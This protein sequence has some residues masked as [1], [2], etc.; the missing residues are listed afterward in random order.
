[1]EKRFDFKGTGGG[2]IVKFIV[3]ILLSIITLGIY[4]SWFAVDLWKYVCSTTSFG[5]TKKGQIQFE[6]AGTGGQLFVI[7]LVG[8]LLMIITI[9]IY[10]PWYMVKLTKFLADHTKGKAQDGTTYRLAFKGSGGDLFVTCIVGWILSVIT[11]G[12]YTPWFIVKL[13]KYFA[14][15]SDILEGETKVGALD[16]TGTGG[17]LFV[18]FLVGYLLSIITLGIYFP[19]FM[20]KLAIY[21]RKNLRAD[22]QGAIHTG[23]FTGAG[24]Q[25]F[26][27]LLVGYLLT[28]VTIGIYGAWFCVDILKFYLNNT[29]FAES[30]KSEATQPAQA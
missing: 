13:W 5:T 19:W 24:G 16:F 29:T 12:I 27:K 6:F 23:G 7:N 25:F 3:G 9:G 1:M 2:L 15:N 8:C 21:Y 30:V 28:L 18:T 10:T 26:V 14:S 4:A 17:D 22:V 11:L 20:V